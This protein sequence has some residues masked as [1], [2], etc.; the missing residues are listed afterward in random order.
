VTPEELRRLRQGVV[1][2]AFISA[3]FWI[4]ILTVWSSALG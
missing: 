3:F 2:G 4:A 1:I